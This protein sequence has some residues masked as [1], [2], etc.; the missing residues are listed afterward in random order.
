MDT[1][2]STH[3]RVLRRRRRDERATRIHLDEVEGLGSFIELE[4]VIDRQS[5]DEAHDE[6]RSIASALEI[7]AT[8]LVALPY[9]DLLARADSRG[10][11]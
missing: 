2:T 6:L 11:A 1:S 5:D 9:A 8:A 7:E 10:G 3:G 4:T